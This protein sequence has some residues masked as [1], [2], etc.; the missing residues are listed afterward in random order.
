MNAEQRELIESIIKENPSYGGDSDLMN[1]I[2]A[3]VY[4]KSYLLLDS[5]SNMENLRNYLVKVVDTS[6]NAILKD[7]NLKNKSSAS[8]EFTNIKIKHEKT[9]Q[10]NENKPETDISPIR[11]FKPQPLP[12]KAKKTSLINPYEG[13]IDPLELVC[14]KPINQALVRNIVDAVQKL[15]TKEPNKKFM[16]IFTMRYVQN[17][18]QS[19]IA[20]NL[21][22]SQSD[23]SKRFYEMVKLVREEIL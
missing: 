4:K 3:E 7:N 17:L 14:E 10:I 2:C 9:F 11:D 20:R 22:L 8:K 21:K 19:A 23:L 13:L 15:H 1:Q 18:D 6:I 5:V 12:L 16:D